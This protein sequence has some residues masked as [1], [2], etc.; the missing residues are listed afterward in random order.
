MGEAKAYSASASFPV[1]A[2]TRMLQSNA[3]K[4]YSLGL[5][6]QEEQLVPKEVVREEENCPRTWRCK[7]IIFAV[8][9]LA[10]VCLMTAGLVVNRD[11]LEKEWKS[12]QQAIHN[13]FDALAATKTLSA[14]FGVAVLFSAIWLTFVR[15]CV[16]TAVYGLFAITLAAELAGAVSLFY[17]GN[18]MSEKWETAWLNG[19]AVLVVL[20]FA[21]TAYTLYSMYHR[22]ALA[23]SM[24]KVAGGVL[25]ELPSVFIADAMLAVCKF[26]W[27]IFCGASAWAI[28]ANTEH[29]VF[30]VGS[31]LAL[32]TYWGLQVLSNIVLAASYGA[33]GEWY[34]KGSARMTGPLVRAFSV[35]FGSVCFG[36]LLI[37]A[38]ETIHDMLH[39]IQQKGAFPSWALCCIDR[40]LAT[41]QSTFDYINKYGFVQVAVHDETFLSAS[42]RA[43]SFLKY[44]G[45]TALVNDSIVFYLARVGAISG[46]LLSGAVPVLMMRALHHDKIDT[47]GLTSDQETTLAF[48]GFFL[49]S[50]VVYTLI[51]PFPAMVTALL[52]CFAEPPEILAQEH[53][54]QYQALIEPWESVYGADF[55]DKAATRANLDIEK[56]GLHMGA[57]SK[58]LL[59]LAQELEKLVALK[60]AGQLSEE[61]FTA[62]KD[63]LLSA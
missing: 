52:V 19:F 20:L 32:M 24:I 5:P 1:H 2:S 3:S 26:L 8:A 48:S 10:G 25:E 59:P 29:N 4:D 14:S 37:A 53:E 41:I 51:S 46:G 54:A 43:I 31:A 27:M 56:S 39:T 40:A 34:Y 6:E 23:A 49:G 57:Q 38:I 7:D 35:H 62:A 60:E 22:V 21:Y 16:R 17:L 50:Y 11:G 47:V 15:Y 30:W 58:T 33:L 61:E 44:K 63:K 13:E 36:S 12:S 55:V 18:T 45:L 9:F 42:K 28:L